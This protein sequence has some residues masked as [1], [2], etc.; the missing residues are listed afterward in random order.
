LVVLA[1]EAVLAIQMEHFSSRLTYDR[2]ESLT[3]IQLFSELAS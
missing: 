3:S 1:L 2:D